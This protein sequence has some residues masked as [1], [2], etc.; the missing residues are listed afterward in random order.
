MNFVGAL[1]YALQILL[2]NNTKSFD[3]LTVEEA[4]FFFFS[5]LILQFVL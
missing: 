1:H 4:K 3:E 5:P 2:G